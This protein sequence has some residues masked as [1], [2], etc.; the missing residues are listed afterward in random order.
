VLTVTS[1]SRRGMHAGSSCGHL[2]EGE[3]MKDLGVDSDNIK[4]D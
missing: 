4:I 3:N 2:K 1:V